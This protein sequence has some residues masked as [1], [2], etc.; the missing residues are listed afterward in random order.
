MSDGILTTRAISQF[1]IN[2]NNDIGKF[3]HDTMQQKTKKDKINEKYLTKN[4]KGKVVTC[5]YLQKLALSLA[6]FMFT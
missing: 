5:L 6:K 1:S 2:M 3:G 4:L